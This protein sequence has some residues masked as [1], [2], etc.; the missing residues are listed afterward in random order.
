MRSHSWLVVFFLCL[1]LLQAD[2]PSILR[3]IRNADQDTTRAGRSN[4]LATVVATTTDAGASEPWLFE[5]LDSFAA[6][7]DVDNM[8]PP[9]RLGAPYAD[10]LVPG[11]TSSLAI[12]V[13]SLSHRSDEATK[14][15]P[16]ARYFFVSIYRVRPG[17]DPS[18]A[19][20]VKMRRSRLETINFDQPEL[21][22]Q[23]I[24]GAPSGTY[25]FLTPLASLKTFDEG[26]AKASDSR[27]VS[28]AEH[29]LAAEVELGHENFLLRIDPARSV[30]P[31]E[32]ASADPDFWRAR[33]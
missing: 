30:V 10:E 15:L 6:L 16:K 17:A 22:Y 12:Y 7:E 26:V 3:I 23:G 24:A 4:I 31:E 9:V 19:D 5:L 27:G 29:K 11:T 14:N 28:P 33:R 8:L 2:P 20:L 13:R 18:F 21:A 25:L 1:P 32:F